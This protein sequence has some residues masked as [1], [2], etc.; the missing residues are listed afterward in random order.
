MPLWKGNGRGMLLRRAV[1]GMLREM[2]YRNGG[3]SRDLVPLWKGNGRGMLLR[4]AVAGMLREM[5][6]CNGRELRDLLP[7]W[8]DAL[9]RWGG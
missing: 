9:W 1:A 3:E 8:M 4:R 6:F 7:L 5:Q 2:P